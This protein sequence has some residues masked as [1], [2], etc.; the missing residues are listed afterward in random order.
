MC[1]DHSKSSKPRLD[2]RA[3]SNWDLGDEQAVNKNADDR[4]QAENG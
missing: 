2:R 1:K 3:I 4:A